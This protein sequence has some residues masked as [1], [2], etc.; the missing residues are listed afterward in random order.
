MVSSSSYPNSRVKNTN[1][2]EKYSWLF[3][4]QASQTSDRFLQQSPQ[5][6]SFVYVYK[7]QKMPLQQPSRKR[8]TSTAQNSNLRRCNGC[9]RRRPDPDFVN[10]R[11]PDH[12]FKSC[13]DCRV[14]DQ[15]FFSVPMANQYSLSDVGPYEAAVVH[16]TRSV[17]CP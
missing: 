17:G 12:P 11:R 2:Q 13:E 14:G 10:E 4:S 3:S 6:T 1:T 9:R 15:P 7:P 8:A 16:H 5:S